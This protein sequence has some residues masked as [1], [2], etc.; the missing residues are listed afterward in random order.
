MPTLNQMP[1]HTARLSKTAH[2]VSQSLAFTAAPGMLLPVY[3]DILVGGDKIDF[4]PSIFSRLTP[5]IA[6]ALCDIEVYLDTFFVPM[7]MLYSFFGNQLFQVR[8]HFSSQ[9]DGNIQSGLRDDFPLFNLNDFNFGGVW[10]QDPDSSDYY[11]HWGYQASNLPNDGVNF[12]NLGSSRFRLLDS[13]GLNPWALFAERS[14][15]Q[16][17]PINMGANPRIFP[18]QLLAY[19]CIYQFYYRMDDWE[20]FTASNFNVDKLVAGY[21]HESWLHCLPEWSVL[22]YRPFLKDYFTSLKRNPLVAGENL[23][24]YQNEGGD[25]FN[26]QQPFEFESIH[27]FLGDNR[28][29][30]LDP[31]ANEPSASSVFRNASTQVDIGGSNTSYITTA[32]IRAAFA[33]EKLM[34]ITGRAGKNYDAQM[35]AHFGVKIPHD[36]KHQI[37]HLGTSKGKFS[38]GEVTSLASTENAELGDF[39]GR[40]SVAFR[41]SNIKFT[42]PCHGVLMCLFSAVPKVRYVGTFDKENALVNRYDLPTPEFMDLGMQPLWAFEAQSGILQELS[43]S[44]EDPSEGAYFRGGDWRLGWQYNYEQYKRK[45]DRVSEAFRNPSDG[46]NRSVDNA[47]K[48]WVMGK[49]PFNSLPTIVGPSQTPDSYQNYFNLS[50]Y[51]FF[52]PP[53]ILNQL[54]QVPYSVE[55]SDEYFTKP[56]LLYQRDPFVCDFHA[57]CTKLSFLSRY[58]EPQL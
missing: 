10:S 53:T 3:K 44:G 19:Q 57:D 35:L 23:L 48:N 16:N 17:P 39:A 40:G 47:Y 49:L 52:C 25:V 45:F 33:L 51:N 4:T 55:W 11:D 27:S 37:S 28:F 2:D 58:G 46:Y 9:F 43:G 36:V 1:K 56:W 54:L 13:L 29:L 7:D 14:S 12:E 15:D 50:A 31:N 32:N 41:G 38:L 22:R 5:L 6:P 26:G 42:A 18:W 24:P 21:P 20:A 30:P 8:E 34:R